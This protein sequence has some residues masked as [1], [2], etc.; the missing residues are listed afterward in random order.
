MA[1]ISIA[2]QRLA[3]TP[4][5][6][7]YL[8]QFLN[9]GDPAGF[10]LAYYSMVG[11]SDSS[12]FGAEQMAQQAKISTFSDR[13]GA[14]A[15][16]ANSVLQESHGALGDRTYEGIYFLSQHV[17]LSANTAIQDQL[18]SGTG[19]IAG[20][21]SSAVS[22]GASRCPGAIWTMSALPS[23]PESWTRQSRSRSGLRPSVS[24]S[25]AT[26]PR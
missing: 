6:T 15:F 12:E 21:A 26:A 13:I 23:P 5:E 9:A 16:L 4:A 22:R 24:V 7:E 8:S 17:A 20:S 1:Q 11:G 2:D 10:Y 19:L 14:V 25:M 18:T 3:L